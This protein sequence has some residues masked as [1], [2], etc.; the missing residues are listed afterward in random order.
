ML[1]IPRKSKE[2]LDEDTAIRIAVTAGISAYGKKLIESEF[3]FFAS[4]EGISWVVSGTSQDF[5]KGVLEAKISKKD[6]RI[7]SITHN[8]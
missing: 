4:L 3:P 1:V 5:A 7:V 8:Q 6:G 2:V